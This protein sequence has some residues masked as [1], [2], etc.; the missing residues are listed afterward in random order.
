MKKYTHIL[1]HT[2]LLIGGRIALLLS[3]TVIPILWIIALSDFSNMP[4][5]EIIVSL[6]L[7]I[8]ISVLL[9]ICVGYMI[10]FLWH[11]VFGEILITQE[12]V[13]YF[14]L[15]IPMIRIKFDNIHFVDI[16]TFDKGNVKYSDIK[17]NV[18]FYKFILISENPLPQKRIDKIIPS[19]K[20][21]LIKYA[22]SEKL[23]YAL[24]DKLPETPSRVVDFQLLMYKKAERNKK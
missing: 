19:K 10:R 4:I 3:V 24:V 11:Q 18:D 9:C 23:C 12:E 22:V 1:P 5:E 8:L 13:I 16:R 14:G 6:I 20:N 17:N 2:M 21:K 15:F 7:L